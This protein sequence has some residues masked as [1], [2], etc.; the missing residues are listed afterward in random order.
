[1]TAFIMARRLSRNGIAK[2]PDRAKENAGM[3][4]E[5]EMVGEQVVLPQDMS[6]LREGARQR[7]AASS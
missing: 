7:L 4:K 3:G 1:M 5:Y 2:N 6:H